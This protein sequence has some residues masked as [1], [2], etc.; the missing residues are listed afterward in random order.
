MIS[1]DTLTIKVQSTQESN[2]VI[3]IPGKKL[4]DEGFI[5]FNDEK[6][7]QD[8]QLGLALMRLVGVVRVSFG[9]DQIFVT[10][11]D[12]TIWDFLRPDIILVISDLIDYPLFNAPKVTGLNMTDAL[13]GEINKILIEKIRPFVVADGGEIEF[14]GHKEKIAYFR[15]EKACA[16]CPNSES[17]LKPRIT[18]LLQ[19]YS[20]GVD[21]VILV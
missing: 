9:I 18:Q 4:M 13:A 17:N 3:F 1:S 8:S 21:S 2:T 6:A 16:G 19:Y 11:T 12:D 15:T 14:L 20:D 10:K 7:A 5:T